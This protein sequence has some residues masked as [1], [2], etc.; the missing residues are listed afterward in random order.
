MKRAVVILML[1]FAA[2]TLAYA[3]VYLGATVQEREAM[4][5]EAPELWW[6][7]QEFHLD[8]AQFQ[9]ISRLHQ[10]YLPKCGETC[11]K[12]AEKNAELKDI[13]SRTNTVTPE[14][15]KKLEEIAQ[16]RAGCQADMLRHFYEV[17]QAMPSEEGRRY[18]AWV[19]QKTILSGPGQMDMGNPAHKMP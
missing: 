11:R 5:S 15:A 2:A 6:L 9:R 8:D 12:I 10:G 14:V 17:S 7:K 3:A 4:K 1:G 19:Q 16:L 13:L 18:L